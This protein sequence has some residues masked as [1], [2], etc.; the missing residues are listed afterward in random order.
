MILPPQVCTGGTGH[1]GCSTSSTRMH[2]SFWNWV[3]PDSSDLMTF[4]HSLRVQFVFFSSK[5]KT[6]VVCRDCGAV[7]IMTN[8]FTGAERNNSWC[9][10]SVNW[11]FCLFLLP[12]YTRVS[13]ILSACDQCCRQIGKGAA[14]IS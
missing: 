5:M 2:P 3:T 13:C 7:K 4:S 11:T 9:F 1:D 14:T 10:L 8:Y 6:F 12:V